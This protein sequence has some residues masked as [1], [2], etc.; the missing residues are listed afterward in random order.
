MTA[1]DFYAPDE[2][3]DFDQYDFDDGFDEWGDMDELD[4]FSLG[5]VWKAAK[6]W[7]G[8]AISAAQTA[9][10]SPASKKWRKNNA[11]TD[12]VVKG[13]FGALKGVK[14][15][16]ACG[17]T[18]PTTD[19]RNA[20]AACLSSPTGFCGLGHADLPSR[21]LKANALSTTS[22][23]STSTCPPACTTPPVAWWT[24]ILLSKFRARSGPVIPP[25]SSNTPISHATAIW[26][27]WACSPKPLLLKSKPKQG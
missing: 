12:A 16:G 9:Y 7:A 13:L 4:D 25:I 24:D 10:G 20:Y 5:D 22:R 17:P 14:N 27:R 6:P 1:M 3:D 11:A 8:T 26:L 23:R 15:D 21:T 18:G 19:C 2:M